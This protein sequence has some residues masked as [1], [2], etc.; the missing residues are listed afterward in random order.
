MDARRYK[1]QKRIPSE[2]L[3]YLYHI[4]PLIYLLIIIPS[5][6]YTFFIGVSIAFLISFTIA[7]LV[8]NS[9]MGL[10]LHHFI[11]EIEIFENEKIIKI[12]IIRKG[13]KIEIIYCNFDDFSYFLKTNNFTKHTRLKFF[14]KSEFFANIF[15]GKNYDTWDPER[16]NDIVKYFKKIE[17]REE[18]N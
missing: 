15:C 2:R 11:N 6:F 4:I 14:I 10:K 18:V 13:A 17:L 8:Y 1:S 9:V 16:V 5:I 7:I 3:I 12:S